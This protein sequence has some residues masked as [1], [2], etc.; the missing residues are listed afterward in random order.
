MALPA[1]DLDVE[2]GVSREAR[3]APITCP[4]LTLAIAAGQRLRDHGWS[5]VMDRLDNLPGVD[6]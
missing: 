5:A 1:T 6:S 4:P 2:S 3:D